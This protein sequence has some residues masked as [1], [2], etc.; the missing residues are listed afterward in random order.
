VA[1]RRPGVKAP[2]RSASALTL[3]PPPCRAARRFAAGSHRRR[4]LQHNCHTD[5]PAWGGLRSARQVLAAHRPALTHLERHELVEF[6]EGAGARVMGYFP[7]DT[8]LLVGAP[9]A[10]EAAASHAAFLWAG[11]F[12]PGHKVAPEWGPLLEQV[13]AAAAGAGLGGSAG[14]RGVGAA[15]NMTQVAQAKLAAALAALP[16]RS[17]RRAGEWP[18]VGI[19]VAFPAAAAPQ[20]HAPDHPHAASQDARIARA[21]RE[22]AETHA[23][24]A[25]AADWAPLLRGHL[26]SG[27]AEVE[28]AGPSHAT[29]FVPVPQL[30]RAVA[31]LAARP[32][33]H[34]VAPLARHVLRN[35]QASC[36]TQSGKPAPTP[37]P[38]SALD[39]GLHPLWAAGITGK[40]QVIGIGD[41]GLGAW[42]RERMHG[43]GRRMR[44]PPP[45]AAPT[46][47]PHSARPL[48]ISPP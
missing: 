40:N 2:P 23:G 18:R 17:V 45:A 3:P 43:G 22:R 24:D 1:P 21:R 36:I 47:S 12:D 37:A 25:A 7:D 26:G 46:R 27:E 4:L 33:A 44:R 31:W 13:E 19:R 5:H 15:L 10:L 35:R 20:P 30:R 42:W 28:A 29:V 6:V 39:P 34:W 14:S 8:L 16:V 48:L 41:S 38:K 9:G 32:A 11:A